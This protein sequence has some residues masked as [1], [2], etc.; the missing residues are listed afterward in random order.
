MSE[1]AYTSGRASRP[2]TL[3]LV[4]ALHGAA[5]SALMLAKMQFD[6]PQRDPPIVVKSY[7]IDPPPPPPLPDQQVK[8][9]PKH[10]SVVVQPKRLVETDVRTDNDVTTQSDPGPALPPLGPIGD[11]IVIADPVPPKA[12]PIRVAA[13]MLGSSILQPDYPSSERSAGREGKVTLRLTISPQG[14]VVAADKVSATSDAFYRAAAAHARREWRFSPATVDGRAIESV[15]VKR[16]TF[17]LE[18]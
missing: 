7:P 12:E 15:I 16:L 3:A 6:A 17:R 9:E 8:A 13:Q 1:M 4:I 5:I 2:A 10:Q 14:R 18:T 11:K